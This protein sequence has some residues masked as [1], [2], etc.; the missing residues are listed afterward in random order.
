M[1]LQH[2]NIRQ[3][4]QRCAQGTGR[5]CRHEHSQAGCLEDS[6]WNAKER[7]VPAH[8]SDQQACLEGGQRDVKTLQQSE[9][10]CIAWHRGLAWKEARGTPNCS[11]SWR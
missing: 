4:A 7:G 3:P 5:R 1:S 8:H 9:A 10:L 2:Y 6:Q 11:L